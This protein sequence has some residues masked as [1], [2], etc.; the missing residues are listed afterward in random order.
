MDPDCLQK[1]IHV[2]FVPCV[3]SLKSVLLYASRAINATRCYTNSDFYLWRTHNKIGAHVESLLYPYHSKILGIFLSRVWINHSWLLFLIYTF[4]SAF[5]AI[6]SA[7][8]NKFYFAVSVE[9]TR[10]SL[11]YNFYEM[12]GALCG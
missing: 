7:W 2:P 3:Q 4:T 5:T 8:K 12:L 9:C 11:K 1:A 10:S 6:I